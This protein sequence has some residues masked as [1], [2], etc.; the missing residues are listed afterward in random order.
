MRN[1]WM[2]ETYL[3]IVM[4]ML[5]FTINVIPCENVGATV[6]GWSPIDIVSAESMSDSRWP[7]QAV[8]SNGTIHIAWSDKTNYNSCGSDYDIFYKTKL[9]NGDWSTTEVISTES[10]G[11]S[12]WPSL[13]ADSRGTIHIAWSDKTDFD[14]CG[15][16]Y[17]IF[18]K[19]SISDTSWETTEVVSPESTSDSWGFSLAVTN[20]GTV[21]L[22]WSDKTDYRD[23][24]SDLDIFYKTKLSGGSWTSAEI[25]STENTGDSTWPS[26]TV[27]PNGVLHIAWSDKTNYN[28]C[29]S[30]Y[31]ILYKYKNVGAIDVNTAGGENNYPPVA[32]AGGPYTGYVNVVITFDASGSSD[33]NQDG[34][35]V[36]Y[37][38]DFGDGTTSYGNQMTTSHIYNFTGNYTVTLTVF[39]DK[40]N[41]DSYVT[42]ANVLEQGQTTPGI[43]FYGTLKSWGSLQLAEGVYI[44]A[45]YSRNSIWLI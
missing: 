28:N 42:Y 27:D 23:S 4:I 34:S 10:T 26:L 11:D 1:H 30:D 18:Y 17:D 3:L 43:S 45:E 22:A 12:R 39:D 13:T 5:F 2:R 31:D 25:I 40:G 15:S 16:D 44:Y 21:F 36:N 20:N 7:S 38:W 24:G 6:D 14:G 41:T 33:S 19:K 32:D 9:S 37:T 35:I 29:G 8:D